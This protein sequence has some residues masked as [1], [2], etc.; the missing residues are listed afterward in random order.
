MKEFDFIRSYLAA[1]PK[2]EGVLLGIGDDAALI[3]PS[4]GF[5][6]CV[7]SDMLLEGRHFF[8]DAAPQDVAHKVLAVNL[9]D[10]AAMGA[11]PRWVS[12]SVALP[13]LR[14]AWLSAFCETWFAL[15]AQYGVSL[16]GGDTTCGNGVFSVSIIGEIPKGKALRRDAAK[17]GDDVWVSGIIGL[18]AV[19]LQHHLGNLSL[20]D[21]VS[22][23]CDEALLR[24]Q[25]R[26]VL[27]SNLLDIAHA[28]QD[29]SDGLLQDLGHIAAASGCGAEIWADKVPLLPELVARMP[30]A[31]LLQTALTGGDD[32]ELLFTAPASERERIADVAELC[33]VPVSRIGVIREG[34]GVTVKDEN[35]RILVFEQQGFDHFV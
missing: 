4:A 32:Y 22:A 25:P 17:V 11:C 10:M 33:G 14:E 8:A 20:P 31:S 23:R 3:R 9:S 26:V 12:L 30:S 15:C 16:I 1:A 13:C 6:L 5:D 18:A 29:V 19:A 28:A 35:G 34:N 2:G 21:A 27:G 24:P 7:S